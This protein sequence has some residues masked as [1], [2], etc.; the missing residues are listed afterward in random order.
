MTYLIKIHSPYG[1]L[2]HGPTNYTGVKFLS[3]F[4]FIINYHG[5]AQASSMCCFSAL[6][7][8]LQAQMTLHVGEGVRLLQR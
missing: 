7:S 1:T 8:P 2:R 5:H 4:Q 3:N 6:T